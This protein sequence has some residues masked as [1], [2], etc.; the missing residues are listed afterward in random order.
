MNLLLLSTAATEADSALLKRVAEQ[1][2]DARHGLA[3]G[4][5][6]ESTLLAMTATFAAFP[7]DFGRGWN[8]RAPRQIRELERRAAIDV[9][10]AFDDSSLTACLPLH[11][12][13][14]PVLRLCLDA[15]FDASTL[16]SPW[17]LNHGCRGVIAG[18]QRI[19]NRLIARGVSSERIRVIDLAGNPAA[20][21]AIIERAC[22]EAM[23]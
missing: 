8:L 5:S 1:L 23:A 4:V 12:T 17:P 14:T 20:V 3:L 2:A 22:S 18:S 16:R 9:L 7:V 13:G 10:L 15:A 11:L 6:R 21:T 19:S